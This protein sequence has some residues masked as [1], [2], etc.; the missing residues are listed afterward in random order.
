MV[1]DVN[2]VLDHIDDKTATPT[3]AAALV[4]WKKGEAKAK[5]ILLDYVTRF[6]EPEP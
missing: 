2:D 1:L 3:N 5:G 4:T 6:A